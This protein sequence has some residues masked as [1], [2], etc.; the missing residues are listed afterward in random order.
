MKTTRKISEP[1]VPLEV[2]NQIE[3]EKIDYS[4]L[5]EDEKK[6]LEVLRKV[7]AEYIRENNI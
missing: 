1:V 3:A 2:W 7:G 5:T 4:K 6:F